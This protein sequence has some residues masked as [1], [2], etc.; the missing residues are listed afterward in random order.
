MKTII[1]ILLIALNSLPANTNQFKMLQSNLISGLIPDIQDGYGVAFRDLNEDGYPD[2]YLVCFRNMNRLLVN[3]GGII[4]FIDRTVFSGL[5]G[6]LSSRGETNLELGANCADYNNDGIPDLF[7]AGWGKTI[8]L[9]LGK[10]QFRF[11]D[12]TEN[13]NI[14]G[15]TDANQGLWLDADND[16]FLDLYITDEHFSNRLLLNNKN[17]TFRNGIWAEGFIDTATSQGAIG[18]DFDGDGDSDIYVTNWH[19]TDYFLLNN[20]SGL[21]HRTTLNLPTLIKPSSSNSAT[22]ADLDNDGRGE[23]IVAGQNGMVYLYRNTSNLG[24]VAFEADTTHPFYRVGSSVYGILAEDFNQDGWLDIFLAVRENH[25]RLYLNN[26]HGNFYPEYDSDGEQG[27]STGS[28]AGDVDGDGDLDIFV[29]NKNMVSQVYLNP[30]NTQNYLKIRLTGV[31]SNRDAVGAK[32]YLYSGRDSLRQLLGF[33]EVSVNIGYLSSKDPELYFGLSRDLDLNLKIIFPSGTTVLRKNLHPGNSYHIYEYGT[34]RRSGYAVVHFIQ[35]HVK[36]RESWFNLVLIL[37]L[38][39]LIFFYLRLGFKRYHW[40]APEM[41]IQLIIWFVLAL[42]SFIGVKDAP[43]FIIIS[44]L[45]G[46]S[47]LSI[48]IS[49][50][51]SEHQYRIRLRRARFR[52][53][54]QLLSTRMINIH[55]N[56]ELQKG[57][58]ETL[59]EHEDIESIL[60]MNYD[61]Q[62]KVLEI[63]SN[64][65]NSIDLNTELYQLLSEQKAVLTRKQNALN[66]LLTNLKLNVAIPVKQGN[67]LLA[68]IGINMQN[69]QSTINREDLQLLL[70][71]ANQTAIAIENN[72]YI[73]E[74]ERLV[75]ELTESKIEQKYVSALEQTNLELDKKN[76]E[77]NR[78]FKELQQKEGQLIHSEK[79][80][81]LGHLVAGISHELNNPISFIYANTKALDS[82][83]S[84]LKNLWNSIEPQADSNLQQKFDDLVREL[85]SIITDN[86]SGSRNVK[87]LVQNLKNFS[88]LDQA[89]W[90]EAHLV[91]GIE[92][93]LKILKSQLSDQI[94]IVRNFHNDPLVFCNPGQLNQ[95]FLN[96]LSNAL[97]AMPGQGTLT[98]TTKVEHDFYIVEISDTGCGI[99]EDI[100]KKIFDP[101]F[102]TK[103]VNQGSGLGLSISYTII[104][105]HKGKLMVESKL[106]Q[107]STFSVHLPLIK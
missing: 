25:N 49:I 54:V 35:F 8:K 2:V 5:G 6:D 62:K 26:G 81:S 89:D 23:I 101:F 20:G 9:F 75:R 28:V 56:D 18:A 12:V 37:F 41:A 52:N 93:S 30:V 78:L 19:S 43:L 50:S 16:G 72:N 100:Q 29:A 66:Q 63:D 40:Q 48:I 7:L 68:V 10:G 103:D 105:G 60:Y 34:L 95:V 88:R 11:N 82:Y 91:E 97:H 84:Q 77:L 51:F 74:S 104:K 4:P 73:K 36:R 32:C 83:L 27:Y 31:R 14:R 55:S 21:F 87:E 53:R 13:L 86:L 98:I 96:L 15:L 47:L 94:K 76:K 17:G 57:I 107:G 71:L 59:L 24:Q 67:E 33:R 22:Y 80:A 61:P 46:V 3:N 39:A 1:L 90:K 65:D 58:R 85:K 99:P 92:S 45:I 69:Y 102:T 44:T 38:S 79:M 106:G 70:P 42:I 64:P